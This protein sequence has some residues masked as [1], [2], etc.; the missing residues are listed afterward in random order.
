MV[1]PVAVPVSLPFSRGL[2]QHP[3][4]SLRST[5][6]SSFAGPNHFPYSITVDSGCL[7]QRNPTQRACPCQPG[8]LAAHTVARLVAKVSRTRASYI[9]TGVCTLGSSSSLGRSSQTRQICP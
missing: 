5:S 4:I 9:G 2:S 3:R 6:W 8:H 7:G 1:P